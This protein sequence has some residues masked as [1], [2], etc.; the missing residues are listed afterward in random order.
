MSSVRRSA[1]VMLVTG[2]FYGLII[3]ARFATYGFDAAGFVDAGV[4]FCDV[5]QMPVPLGLFSKNG[6]DGQFYYRLALDPFTKQQTAF[7]ITLDI[8]PYRQ[9][10]ILYPMLVHALA[11]GRA[12]WVPWALIAVNYLAICALSFTAS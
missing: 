5:K 6:Y 12:Q 2:L 10:R 1:G 9:Q 11:L 4:N 8:P 3:A 7:G